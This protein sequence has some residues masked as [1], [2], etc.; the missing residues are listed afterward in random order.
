MQSRSYFSGDDGQIDLFVAIHDVGRIGALN[1]VFHYLAR[2]EPFTAVSI[3]N[4]INPSAKA[5][6]AA[7]RRASLGAGLAASCLTVI[8]CPRYVFARQES[9]TF[10][11][12]GTNNLNG[13][14]LSVSVRMM[15]WVVWIFFCFMAFLTVG[16]VSIAAPLPRSI[17]VLNESGMVGPFYRDAY[18]ALRSTVT[19][20]SS[21]PVSINLEQLELERFGGDHYEKTLK[22]YLESKYVDKP[23]GVI[24]ALGFGALDFVL[25]L[26]TEM[27]AGVPVVFA[28]VDDVALQRLNIP[29]DVTGRT[30]RVR[31]QDFLDA[32]HIVVPGLQRIAIVGDRWEKQTAFRQLQKEIPATS[33]ALE[34]IDLVGLPMRELKKRVAVLPERTA[35]AYTSIFSDGEGISYPPVDALRLVA[36]VANRPIVVA[37]ETFLGGGAVGGYVL[38][39]TAVGKGAADLALRILRAY[40]G[41]V[42]LGILN[43]AEL[44]ECSGIDSMEA[45]MPKPCS[46]DLRERV[47]EAVMTGASRREAAERFEISASSAVKWLQR[48]DK[49]GS[50]AAKPTGGS[51][52]PLEKHA[53]FLLGLI[54]E[55]PDLTLDEVVAAMRG[56]RIKGSRS[57]VWRLF[58]RHGIGF[59]KKPAGSGARASRC[60]ARTS[61]LDAKAGRV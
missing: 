42:E 29:P 61:A 53:N 47:L 41:W 23:I 49:T 19:A 12:V 40:L 21:Q 13:N 1:V 30:S 45:S 22:T 55:Q 26:R 35:I 43:F 14:N 5:Q 56:R 52:S 36:E 15:R 48:W 57:A 6:L 60:G 59:K 28:M 7:I 2:G 33:A 34:I 20:N 38:T 18:D 25:R 11:S 4:H 10:P 24:V 31:F 3:D 37:A 44:S 58:D 8:M 32:A 54:A 17:L 16:A 46:V 50:I 51:T 27:F 9:Y 39:P